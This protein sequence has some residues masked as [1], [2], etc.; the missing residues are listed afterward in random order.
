MGSVAEPEKTKTCPSCGAQ[1]GDPT[2]RKGVAEFGRKFTILGDDV[3]LCVA[4]TTRVVAGAGWGYRLPTKEDSPLPEEERFDELFK[5][6]RVLLEED[7]EENQIIPTLVLANHLCHGVP[8]LLAEKERLVELWDR[9]QVWDEE[10]H[11]FARRFGGLLPVRVVDGVLILERQRALVTIGYAPAAKTPQEVI[12]TVYPHRT[13]LAKAKEVASQYEQTLSDAGIAH[14]EECAV[15]LSSSR[16]NRRL[17]ICIQ[18]GTIVERTIVTEGF[19]VAQ[20]GWRL[21]KKASFPQPRLVGD[22]CAALVAT[23]SAEGFA[24]ELPTRRRSHPPKPENLVPACVAFLLDG[25]GTDHRKIYRLLDERVL[26]ETW[27]SHLDHG[28][29]ERQSFRKAQTGTLKNQVSKLMHDD[30]NVRDP[31]MDAAW[32][33]FWEGYE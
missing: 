32:T 16:Y 8:R 12:I 31:L 29:W 7:A 10:V 9:G 3:R 14:D 6:A 1:L 20:A 2:Q 25:Y 30:A 15:R 33:L 21:D 4:C 27:K 24:A 13:P 19:T 26:D 17:E 18:P 5:A 11:R 22:L 28:S 23:A